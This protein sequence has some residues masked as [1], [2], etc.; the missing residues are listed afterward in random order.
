VQITPS[1][2]EPRDI[3][4]MTEEE[5]FETFPSLRE[6][7]KKLGEIGGTEIIKLTT[8]PGGVLPVLDANDQLARG[9]IIELQAIPGAGEKNQC[10]ANSVALFEEDPKLILATG[11]VLSGDAWYHHSWCIRESCGQRVIIETTPE[12]YQNY[13]GLEYRGK[14][15]DE[16]VK[17]L[18]VWIGPKLEPG[19]EFD[20]IN[21]VLRK[22]EPGTPREAP[23]G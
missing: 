4:P 22:I 19:G 9:E 21:Q 11:F 16:I 15:A 12:K 20:T 1:E 2:E 23:H 14:G 13:F 7:A 3:R 5:V 18:R 10:H 17:Q 8:I 6:L